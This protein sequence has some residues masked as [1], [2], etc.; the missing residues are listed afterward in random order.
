MSLLSSPFQPL[1]GIELPAKFGD[2]I[3]FAIIT[4]LAG[5]SVTA[6]IKIGMGFQT[7]GARRRRVCRNQ[8]RLPH[9]GDS[10]GGAGRV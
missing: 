5:C 1:L 10:L 8:E 4:V 2:I 9:R 3:S 7:M 6:M